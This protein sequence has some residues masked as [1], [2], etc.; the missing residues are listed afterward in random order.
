MS[1]IKQQIGSK[2]ETGIQVSWL[3]NQCFFHRT[4]WFSFTVWDD[5]YISGFTSVSLLENV[6]Q[7]FI[8]FSYVFPTCQTSVL[9]ILWRSVGN[10]SLWEEVNL[11]FFLNSILPSTL[12]FFLSSIHLSI[13]LSTHLSIHPYIHLFDSYWAIFLSL[14]VTHWARRWGLNRRTGH[15]S[16]PWGTPSPSG[17]SRLVNRYMTSW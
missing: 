3:P 2:T 15:S 11:L 14:C 12:S 1:K 9:G 5:S 6:I 13:H 4:T 16:I 10:G 7:L 8:N 17:G